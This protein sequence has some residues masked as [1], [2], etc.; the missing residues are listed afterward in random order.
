MADPDTR[1]ANG[2]L[3][4]RIPARHRRRDG[5]G[6]RRAPLNRHHAGDLRRRSLRKFRLLCVSGTRSRHRLERFR[7]SASGCVG[8]GSASTGREHLGR[9]KAKWGERGAV[10]KRGGLMRRRLSGRSA[11]SRQRAAAAALVPAP[12]R[13]PAARNGD[14][15]VAA[16]RDC[17]S[18]QAC[19]IADQRPRA[20]AVHDDAGRKAVHRRRAAADYPRSESR[21]R[22]G[23]PPRW[24][25]T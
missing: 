11:F 18:G 21:S 16:R 8:V 6:R 20:A 19:A 7:R 10:R 25:I 24:T 23:S 9:R 14:R 12:R 17:A 13:R 2:G 3:A 15:K 22:S 1:R 5:R 4:V